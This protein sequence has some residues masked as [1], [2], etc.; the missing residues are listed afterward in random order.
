MNDNR[1]IMRNIST[2]QN[3]KITSVIERNIRFWGR[4]TLEA[5]GIILIV[6]AGLFVL[7]SFGNGEKDLLTKLPFYL[8]LGG[9]FSVMMMAIGYFQVYFS[10]LVSMNCKRTAVAA[11][12]LVSTFFLIVFVNGG[13]WLIWKVIGTVTAKSAIK[14][15]PVLTGISFMTGAF[16]IMLGVIITRW[17]K[18]GTILLTAVCMIVGGLVGAGVIAIDGA[19]ELM[20]ILAEKGLWIVAVI[21]LVL[22]ILAGI[23]AMLSVRKVE[24]RS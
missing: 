12:I 3:R 20:L 11:G 5:I 23:F 8:Y 10:M 22:Y 2:V 17:G 14:I 19:F 16:S 15:I 9:G 24:I 4:A 1:D 7:Y 18:I 6:A 13:A 21:G